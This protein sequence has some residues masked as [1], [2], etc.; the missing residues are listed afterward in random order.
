MFEKSVAET[1]FYRPGGASVEGLERVESL[2]TTAGPWTSSA[3]HA[4]PPAALLVRA[5]EALPEAADRVVAR[6]A[7][8][9]L[10]PVPIGPLA[11]TATVL[12][13]GRSVA[14]VEAELHDLAAARVVARAPA[15]LMPTGTA[16][17][18]TPVETLDHAPEDG[19]SLERPEG[20]LGGYLDAIEWR[21]ISGSLERPGPGVVWMRAP[22]LVEGQEISPLQRL[23]ACVDSASGIG[24]ALDVTQWAFMNTELTVHVLRPPVGP[25][26]CVD[27]TT[28]LVGTSVG[29]A[30]S[31]VHDRD[32]LVAR[33]SQALLV[34][35]R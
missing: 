31:T 11:T 14:L 13:P 1:P 2:P 18:S 7:V 35:R 27:A 34:T 22:D 10:G 24:S 33:S 5:L 29:L 19:L 21:W 16:G 30:T 17:P 15:W 9:L 26:L 12:R 4:G 25:W 8:D 3:Q 23:V 20:W 32:G 6:V 28:T